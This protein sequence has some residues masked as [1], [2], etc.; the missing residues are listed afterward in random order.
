[1]L[2]KEKWDLPVHNMERNTLCKILKL[3]KLF[4]LHFTNYAFTSVDIKQMIEIQI[5]VV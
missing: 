1:M 5:H 3:Q 2:L 4:L